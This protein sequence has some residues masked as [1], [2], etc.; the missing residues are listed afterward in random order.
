MRP[1]LLIVAAAALG[2]CSLL[3]DFDQEVPEA[4]AG[5]FD[6]LGDAGVGQDPD[7]T[8]CGPLCS[9]LYD[10]LS[11]PD[12][13]AYYAVASDAQI[14]DLTAACTTSCQDFDEVTRGQYDYLDKHCRPVAVAYVQ[15]DPNLEQRCRY[16]TEACDQLC[17]GDVFTRCVH[18]PAVKCADACKNAPATLWDCM[19]DQVQRGNT[20]CDALNTCAPHLNDIGGRRNTR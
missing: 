3:L 7:P 18:L 12:V 2:G 20:A 9:K 5:L 1:A 13:C 14:D 4:D 16:P 19:Y 8:V 6:L 17:K 10:C 11:Q 15:S